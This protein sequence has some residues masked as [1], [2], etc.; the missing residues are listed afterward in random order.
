MQ[1]ARDHQVEHQPEAI[2]HADRDAFADSSQLANGFSLGGTWRWIDRAQQE[3]R[4]ESYM[5]EDL[6]DD[7]QLERSDVRRDVG[8]FRHCIQ[9]AAVL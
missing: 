9:S 2:I 6:A 3:Y 8:K 4:A 5:L 7:A 1:A